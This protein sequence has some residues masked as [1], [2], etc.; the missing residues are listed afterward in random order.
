MNTKRVV[1]TGLLIAIEIVMS[2]FL[3]IATPI[4]KISFGFI[5]IAIAAMLYGPVYAGIAAAA[6]DF[7]GA[8]LFPIGAFFPG[9][10]LSALL[11]GVTYGFLLHNH[12][13]NIKRISASA[14]IICM[15]IN[16]VLGS[17]WLS[18]LMKKALFLILPTRVL[19]NVIMIPIQVITIMAAGKLVESRHDFEVA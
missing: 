18:I 8:M 17:L 14:T 7:I 5:P 2:R 1:Q 9:F 4:V 3:S 10:T 15:G 6:A 11:R 12:P 19:H 13:T 16:L